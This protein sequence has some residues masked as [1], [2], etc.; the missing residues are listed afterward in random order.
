M[1]NPKR[2][3]VRREDPSRPPKAGPKS[4]PRPPVPQNKKLA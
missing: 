1:G 3:P 2:K 4:N